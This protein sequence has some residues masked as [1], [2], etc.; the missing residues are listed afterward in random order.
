[1]DSAVDHVRNYYEDTQS[2]YTFTAITV[3]PLSLFALK[4]L[5]PIAISRSRTQPKIDGSRILSGTLV[6]LIIVLNLNVWYYLVN[7][8]IESHNIYKSASGPSFNLLNSPI[9]EKIVSL[10]YSDLKIPGYSFIEKGIDDIENFKCGDVRFYDDHGVKTS[11]PQSLEQKRDMKMIRDQAL[12][13]NSTG[14]YPII[15]KCFFDKDEEKE[16]DILKKKWYKFA[17]SS[18]WLDKYQVY[19]L[20]SRVVYSHRSI[21]NKPTISIAYAQ[22]FNRNWEELLDYQFPQSDLVFPAILPVGLD[23]HPEG[24]N[25]YLG[26]DDPRVILRNYN[27]TIGDTQEQEPVIIYNSYR[28]DIGW[29]RAIHVY[30]PL[31]NARVAVPLRLVG[32][33]PRKREK[34]WAPFFDEDASSI[35]FVYSFNP[36]RIIKCDY[37]NG[38]CN[39][40]SGA[41]FEK[42]DARALRGGTN[43]VRVPSSFF[44]KH[45]AGK[46]EYWFGIARS[47]D[48]DCGCIKTIYRPHSFVISKAYNTNDYTLDYV[49]SL[50]D[51]NIDPQAWNIKY[52]MAKCTDSKSVLIPNSIAYWDVV[53]TKNKE[54][55]DHLEDIMGVTFSEADNNNRLIHV[56]GFLQ[57]VTSIF[58]GEKE[59]IVDHYSHFETVEEENNLL[60]KCATSLAQ[61]YCKSTAKKFKWTFAKDD[62][63]S[64]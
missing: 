50:F 24:A 63:N 61:Q 27:D 19:F 33:K 2:L 46:R 36:L 26:A 5:V 3:T 34:N 16:E 9:S 54:G 23:E 31:T 41:P 21:R 60:S 39:K 49:S 18:T 15:R 37:N 1:M 25:V 51:F 40:I 32:M 59:I 42:N 38:D 43:I 13:M 53:T 7:S 35:N 48:D 56:K 10:E 58:S 20:V 30:R 55:K 17:G 11:K 44:P 29:K 64:I 12:R 22:V 47:H 6:A 8:M 62:N 4:K 45:L 57:H 52:E 28:A 14:E